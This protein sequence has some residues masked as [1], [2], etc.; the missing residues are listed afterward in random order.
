MLSLEKTLLYEIKFLSHTFYIAK[1]PT[2][3]LGRSFSEVPSSDPQP[4]VWPDHERV[5][6]VIERIQAGPPLERTLTGEGTIQER[7]NKGKE[8]LMKRR[9]ENRME[10]ISQLMILCMAGKAMPSPSDW[11]DL[12]K[13][14]EQSLENIK[15]SSNRTNI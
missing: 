2:N 1:S 13:V 11:H 7:I 4:E 10:E 6:Q 5:Q 12:K 15:P 9:M 14:V 3:R 8:L